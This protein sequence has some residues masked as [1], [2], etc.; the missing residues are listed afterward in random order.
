MWAGSRRRDVGSSPSAD[1][2]REAFGHNRILSL[3]GGGGGGGGSPLKRGLGRIDGG[4]GGILGGVG[5]RDHALLDRRETRVVV[6][7]G[8]DGRGDLNGLVVRGNGGGLDLDGGGGGEGLGLGGGVDGGLLDSGGGSGSGSGDAIG[9]SDK[10][11][12]DSL[13]TRAVIRSEF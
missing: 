3:L 6:D 8:V 10:G 7:G 1:A 12:T 13:Q 2:Y 4:D 11:G 9:G 5:A